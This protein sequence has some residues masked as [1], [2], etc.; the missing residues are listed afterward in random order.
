MEK[1]FVKRCCRRVAVAVIAVV[2]VSS[3]GAAQPGSMRFAQNWDDLSPDQRN[4]ALENYQRYKKL[5]E[6]KR[7]S[8]DRSYDR[9]RGMDPRNQERVRR[10]YESYRQLDKQQRK[11][12]GKRYEQWRKGGSRD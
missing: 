10:N 5:P 2:G 8:L 4:R 6:E 11:D 9:W 12:F 3:V 7:R 1:A